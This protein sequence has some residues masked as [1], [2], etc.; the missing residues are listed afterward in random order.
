MSAPIV[1]LVASVVA[2]LNAA[3]EGTF[4][5]DFEAAP[6]WQRPEDAENARGDYYSTLR[7]FVRPGT[8]EQT[9]LTRGGHV[10][11]DLLVVVQVTKQVAKQSNEHA[12]S[13]AEIDA[14]VAFVQELQDYMRLHPIG[15]RDLPQWAQSSI[16]PVMSLE[17][18]Q[19]RRQFES[20]I[21]VTYTLVGTGT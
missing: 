15:D 5:Q 2:L 12:A 1:A 10:R 6:V 17:A 11:N 14:L 3:P 16:D 18:L 13:L 4:S 19:T 21:L 8:V 20:D 9:V 7:V